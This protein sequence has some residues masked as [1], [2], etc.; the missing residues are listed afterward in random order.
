MSVS[1]T[2]A[3]SLLYGRFTTARVALR[4][5]SRKISEERTI[6]TFQR[7]DEREQLAAWPRVGNRQVPRPTDPQARALR[8]RVTAVGKRRPCQVNQKAVSVRLWPR[9]CP[10]KDHSC[11]RAQR[12]PGPPQENPHGT[13][14]GSRD[15]LPARRREPVRHHRTHRDPLR[16]DHLPRTPRVVL[17]GRTARPQLH[18]G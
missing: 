18:R 3:A 15:R 1:A 11:S 14:T 2:V 16:Q 5:P 6:T 12:L 4:S 8:C 17:Q 9:S 7:C 10:V 13:I